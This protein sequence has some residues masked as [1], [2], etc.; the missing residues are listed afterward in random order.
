[1]INLKLRLQNKTT[2]IAIIGVLVALVYQILGLLGIAVSIS[3]NDILNVL[4]TLL[5][6]LVLLGV[7]IDPTTK[8]V[9][10]STQA[11][12]YTEPK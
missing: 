6:A 1:M 8:G 5:N 7:I 9:S 11:M 3:Q 12:E 10:D 4:Y 2:L